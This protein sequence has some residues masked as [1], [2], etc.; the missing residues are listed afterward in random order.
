V[1]EESREAAKQFA[2]VIAAILNME[3]RASSV[4]LLIEEE[5]YWEDARTRAGR[6]RKPSFLIA[7]CGEFSSGKSMLLGALMRR[8]ELFPDG[9]GATTAV[10]TLV[11]WGDTERILVRTVDRPDGFAIAPA[12]LAQYVTESGNPGNERHVAE[13]L[14]ELPVPLMADGICFVDLPGTG[15]TYAVHA[16]VTN[17]YLERIDAAIFVTPAAAMKKSEVDFLRRVTARIGDALVVTL[18]KADLIRAQYGEAGVANAVADLRK[19]AADGLG[20]TLESLVIIPVS[21]LNYQGALG[22]LE[23][24]QASNIPALE[25]AIETSISAR[26]GSLLAADALEALDAA[27]GSAAGYG[28]DRLTALTEG[29]TPEILKLQADL[30]ERQLWLRNVS[31]RQSEWSRQLRERLD[32]ISRDTFHELNGRLYT[33]RSDA[34]AALDNAGETLD[35]NAFTAD[36]INKVHDQYVKSASVLEEQV[37]T[38]LNDVAGELKLSL[39]GVQADITFRGTAASAF[40]EP[41]PARRITGNV[42]RYGEAANRAARKSTGWRALGIGL[43]VIGGVIATV[44]TGGLAAGGLAAA[45]ALAAGA[46]TGGAAGAAIGTAAATAVTMGDELAALDRV[47]PETRRRR[48]KEHIVAALTPNQSEAT[49]RLTKVTDDL[50]KTAVDTLKRTMEGERKA[51]EGKIDHIS[52]DLERSK[53]DAAAEADTL[54]PQV[55]SLETELIP[56]AR[57]LRSK[58]AAEVHNLSAWKRTPPSSDDQDEPTP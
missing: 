39:G 9:V 7:V 58:V 51:I 20:V 14:V 32:R 33:I 12:D 30:A 47:D 23:E 8:P 15:S 48:L 27:F 29:Q 21:A 6:L 28:R 24:E 36:V 17:A 55:E 49:D 52:K 37:N 42:R 19:K 10:P 38:A 31:S 44:A 18:A 53:A 4:P 11:R 22:D 1:S 56:E 35:A 41:V 26:A 34:M 16:M 50:L 43:G 5:E 40:I 25:E 45:I 13:V 3:E 54:R 57:R 2:D 46:A